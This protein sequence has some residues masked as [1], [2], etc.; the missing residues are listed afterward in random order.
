LCI[1]KYE[2]YWQQNLLEAE[3]RVKA[4]EQ[5][6]RNLR[7]ELQK[8]SSILD[9]ITD[10][11]LK[12]RIEPLFKLPSLP[13][14]MIIRDA[15]VVLE[16]RLRSVG[17]VGSDLEGVRLVDDLLTPSTGKLIFSSHAG[18]QEGVRILYR[19]AMQ[20]IRNPPMHKLIE[21]PVDTARLLIRL[22]DALLQLLTEAKSGHRV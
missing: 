1:N 11:V 19:G 3:K 18:E 2:T 8:A 22:I 6:N 21:Y 10:A 12:K 7:E 15:S 20:F 13:L 17:I 14:D 9:E 4:L 5:D 16:D